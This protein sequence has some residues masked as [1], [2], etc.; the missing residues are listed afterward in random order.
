MPD[1]AITK[2]AWRILTRID[3]HL[4]KMPDPVRTF[5]TPRM[6]AA[7]KRE[8]LNHH[9]EHVVKMNIQQ[10]KL[11]HN[12]LLSW[13]GFILVKQA[14]MKDHSIRYAPLTLVIHEMND[15]LKACYSSA[16]GMHNIKMSQSCLT[17]LRRMAIR[18]G[19]DDDFAIGKN[20]L[21]TAFRSAFEIKDR[22][23]SLRLEGSVLMN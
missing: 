16:P 22:I 3:T 7:A 18:D 4:S 20:G 12:K 19:H 10:N 2:A 8:A 6:L 9:A 17:E 5:W 1:D 14:Y 21:Y 13:Y 11:D 23:N 15:L